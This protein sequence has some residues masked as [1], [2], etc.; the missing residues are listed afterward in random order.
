MITVKFGFAFVDRS[1]DKFSVRPYRFDPLRLNYIRFTNTTDAALYVYYSLMR[2]G[3]FAYATTLHL[4]IL[5][6]VVAYSSCGHHADYR[7]PP[8]TAI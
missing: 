1:I 4:K 8:S 2:P 7:Q 5:L 6:S 3:I